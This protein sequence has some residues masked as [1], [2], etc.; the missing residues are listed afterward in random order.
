MQVIAPQLFET[1][2]GPI[3]VVTEGPA[4]GHTMQKTV[5]KR[6]PIDEWADYPAQSVCSN[7][8]VD[9]YLAKYK[10]ILSQAG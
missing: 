2:D 9:A 5:E 1:V 10:D 4:I 6:F 8:D 7:V 3:R